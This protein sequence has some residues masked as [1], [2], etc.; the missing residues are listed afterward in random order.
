MFDDPAFYWIVMAGLA[1]GVALLTWWQ[2]FDGIRSDREY[3]HRTRKRERLTGAEFFT[4]FYAESGIPA[5]LVV[6]F[7]DFHAG[8][9]G[10]EPALLRPED[11]L[12]R[13]HA[14]ADCAGWA[15]EVQT[16]FGV[17]VP[18]RVPPELWAV[19]PVHEPTFD[20][21]LR[22]IRAVRDLQRAA[23]PRAAPDPVK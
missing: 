10:E 12:F 22:Y 23:E 5:E 13:V 7:R 15:A 19:V 11:D 9:W 18:E 2:D 3:Q 16:R 4:R 8:Y 17:V 1:V 6:A 20:T 21:V 14:G